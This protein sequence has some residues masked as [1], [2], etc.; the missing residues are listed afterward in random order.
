MAE[1]GAFRVERLDRLPL[2][3]DV[4][5]VAGDE[6]RLGDPGRQG[7]DPGDPLGVEAVVVVEEEDEV[8]TGRL[9]EVGPDPGDDAPLL[10]EEDP[11][12]VGLVPPEDRLRRL[13]GAVAQEEVLPPVARLG[14]D[15]SDRILE[16]GRP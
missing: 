15:A 8:V 14:Q 13:G 16:V 4:N 1:A 2:P 12:P 10:P 11:G 7:L 3:V 5:G 9:G 6:T